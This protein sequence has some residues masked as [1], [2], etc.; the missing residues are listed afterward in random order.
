M[1]LKWSRL[2]PAVVNKRLTIDGAVLNCMPVDIMIQK[3]VGKIIAVDLSPNKTY[4]V[5]YKARLETVVLLH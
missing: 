1:I 2:P 4:E 5:D 3:P